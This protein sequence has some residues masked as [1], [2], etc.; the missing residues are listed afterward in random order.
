LVP[1]NN[2]ATNQKTT[3]PGKVH[4]LFCLDTDE[5]KI[6]KSCRSDVAKLKAWYEQTL[7]LER[8]GT[9]EFITAAD[10]SVESV[11]SH[12]SNLQTQPDDKIFVYLGC[13][14][15]FHGNEHVLKLNGKELH[16]SKL[17]ETLKR[18]PHKL[19]VLITDS[20]G[21]V[22]KETPR[23]V[24]HKKPTEWKDCAFKTMILKATG[25]ADIN[26]AS[27]GQ[28]AWGDPT[29]A[30]FT[31]KF[32]ELCGGPT[33]DLDLNQDGVVSWDSEFFPKMKESTEKAYKDFR[34]AVM[35]SPKFD[36][37]EEEHYNL[38]KQR[39]QS[40]IAFGKLPPMQARGSASGDSTAVARIVLEVPADA[41]LR[42]DDVLIRSSGAI[43]EFNTPKLEAGV[44]YSY[45]VTVEAARGGERRTVSQAVDFRAGQ[46]IRVRIDFDTEG[47]LVARID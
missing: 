31:S 2:Q 20:C 28:I 42:V 21:T 15:E 14:G 24:S 9:T 41:S 35:R 38:E 17:L 12:C 30:V 5:K 29:G 36:R 7:P 46:A 44:L 6:G 33:A 8:Q 37:A 23:D 10:F 3:D 39:D 18:H 26:S 11:L 43:R 13:H 40:P 22:T 27:P 34:D 47:R 16:R 1:D 25:V 45:N 32:V 4:A 19:L